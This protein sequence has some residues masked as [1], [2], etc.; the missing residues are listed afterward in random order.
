MLLPL[1]AP[2]QSDGDRAV[3]TYFFFNQGPLC[4]NH[5]AS[6]AVLW[7]LRLWKPTETLEQVI[8][9]MNRS[10]ENGGNSIAFIREPLDVRGENP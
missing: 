7:M 8:R 1:G 4:G 3:E 6:V 5:T 2:A 10:D 9:G